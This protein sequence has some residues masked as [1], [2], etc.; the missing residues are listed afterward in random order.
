MNSLGVDQTGVQSAIISH[1]EADVRARQTLRDATV[2]LFNA[3]KSPNVTDAQI[4]AIVNEARGI[5][6]YDKTRRAQAQDAL[7]TKIAYDLTP[8]VEAM[9]MLMGM[10]GDSVLLPGNSGALAQVER[11][12]NGLRKDVDG[13]KIEV[14]SLRNERDEARAQR[15]ALRAEIE[16]LKKNSEAAKPVGKTK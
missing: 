5:T 16:M 15:D 10:Q 3:V 4:S 7:K 12:R 9:L 13:L 2:K 11:E 1:I 8:R 6:E 14:D